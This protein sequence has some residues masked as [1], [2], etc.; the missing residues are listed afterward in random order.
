MKRIT[1]ALVISSFATLSLAHHDGDLLDAHQQ[2]DD[3]YVGDKADGVGC[4]LPAD[5]LPTRAPAD[6]DSDGVIDE[7]DQCPN[8][9][10]GA[11]VDVV[12]CDDADRDGIPNGVDQCPNSAPGALVDATGCADSDGD[13]VI[14][15]LDQCPVTPAGKEVDA[16][17]CIELRMFELTGVLFETDSERL[18]SYALAKLDAV[19]ADVLALGED[20]KLFI[21]GHADNRGDD[22]YNLL[23]SQRRADSVMNYFLAKGLALRMLEARGYGETQP[24]SGEET[25]EGW[26]RNRRVII[27]VK[28]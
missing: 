16:T 17:G 14:D 10:P 11:R 28:Y 18:T 2:C 8:S 22:H 3:T 23:L 12:G 25:P 19:S 7:R 26:A 27:R 24:V 20:V 9:V 4:I 5:A 21:E 6:S 1:V 15:K 13:G